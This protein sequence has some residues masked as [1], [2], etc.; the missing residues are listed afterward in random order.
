MKY[1]RKIILE[2]IKN[3]LKE[4]KI[5]PDDL[6][7]R[8]NRGSKVVILQQKL[9]DLGLMSFKGG[10]PTGYYGPITYAAILK[11]QKKNKLKKP[12]FFRIV[13]HFLHTKDVI[14]ALIRK[15]MGGGINSGLR[16]F[17]PI[18]LN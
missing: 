3:I 10:K 15:K 2:E 14:F 16:K 18:I 8:G 6:L 13:C 11:Y 1:L 4:A 7:V 5:E 9:Q 17:K 12:L